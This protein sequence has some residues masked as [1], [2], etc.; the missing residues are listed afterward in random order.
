MPMWAAMHAM[1]TQ[2]GTT[3]HFVEESFGYFQGGFVAG[4]TYEEQMRMALQA[5]TPPGQVLHGQAQGGRA[6]RLQGQSETAESDGS[7]LPVAVAGAAAGGGGTPAT[8]TDPEQPLDAAGESSGGSLSAEEG[9]A[10]VPESSSA[11]P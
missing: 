5:S 10:P 6:F 9:S 4:M 1:R 3:G 11:Q 2:G 8:A 7:S